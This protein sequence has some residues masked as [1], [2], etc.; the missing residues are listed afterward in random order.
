MTGVHDAL[1]STWDCGAS[2]TIE[3]NP[4]VCTTVTLPPIA[5]A[6][7][8]RAARAS[9]SQLQPTAGRTGS[10]A[11]SPSMSARA[12]VTQRNVPFQAS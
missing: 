1:T 11:M 10:A 3:P 5:V 4:S 8:P 7:A 12:N 9:S 6:S 2:S